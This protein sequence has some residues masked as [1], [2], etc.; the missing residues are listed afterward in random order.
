MI[1]T[2]GFHPNKTMRARAWQLGKALVRR[3][4]TVQIFMP[5]WHTPTEAN[6]QWEEGGVLI[7]YVPLKGGVAG[8]TYRLVDEVLAWQPEM[9][10]CFKPKAYSGLAGAWL[11]QF[12]RH[13]LRL[14]IDSDDW[15]GAGGWND[16][17]NYSPIQKQFFAW[18]ER[19]GMGHCHWLTVASRT[20][21]SLAWAQ[22]I[23]PEQVLYLP[24]GTGIAAERAERTVDQ[25]LALGLGER[26]T[27]LLYSR[28]FEFEVERLIR[29]LQRVQEELPALAILAVGTGLFAKEAAQ[30]RQRFQETDL[31]NRVIDVG[32][33]EEEKLPA[34]LA[35]ADVGIYLMEDNLLNRTKCPVKLADMLAC[36]VPVVG[37]AVGQVGEYIIAEQTGLL[38]ATGD[39][40]GVATD[41]LRLL[42]DP[43]C[44]HTFSLSAGQHMSRHF[45][46]DGLAR[47]FEERVINGAPAKN[48]PH[49]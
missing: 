20:L 4:H 12:H 36:G 14:V 21:Q 48:L 25:R 42:Q 38:R 46:W 5:P 37:E 27:L 7:R 16:R 8:I 29:I 45:S 35:C 43:L 30:L 22:G 24:N 34:V 19:W 33:I 17:A 26:P 3:G 9:V 28:L 49:R 32:W 44:R 6:R 23:I 18:Q 40:V 15:E 39:E 10:Y 47:A 2:F 1:G 31:M 11:W 13:R 41:L